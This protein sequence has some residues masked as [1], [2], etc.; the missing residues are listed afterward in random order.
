MPTEHNFMF[1]VMTHFIML[2]CDHQVPKPSKTRL[3]NSRSLQ[4][5][6]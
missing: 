4:D 5:L 2:N 6:N 1:D 3:V